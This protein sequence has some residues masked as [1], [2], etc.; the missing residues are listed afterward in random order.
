MVTGNPAHP[1]PMHDDPVY[2]ET[3]DMHCP[4]WQRPFRPVLQQVPP[5]P[6]LPPSPMQ[7]A[8]EG[9]QVPPTLK[10]EQQFEAA[11]EATPSGRQTAPVAGVEDAHATNSV[12]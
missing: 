6:Q 5:P 3:A 9:A 10:P 4:A 7:V 1:G 8:A 2:M 11:A 12:P